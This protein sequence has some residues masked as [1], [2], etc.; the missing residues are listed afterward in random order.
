[1]TYLQKI[2]HFDVALPNDTIA[3]FIIVKGDAYILTF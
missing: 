2:T 3:K 1:M